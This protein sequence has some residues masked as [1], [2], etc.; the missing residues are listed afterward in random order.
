MSRRARVLVAL[1]VIALVSPLVPTVAAV[2][3][4]LDH[5]HEGET[6][7]AD[8]A[9]LGLHGHSHPTGT[10][11]HEHGLSAPALAT[12]APRERVVT[13]LVMGGSFALLTTVIAGVAPHVPYDPVARA[14]PSACRSSVLRI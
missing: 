6:H 2:H 8:G 12:S 10:P 13:V 1:A 11:A 14:S 5:D 4:L 9:D 7:D 3:V